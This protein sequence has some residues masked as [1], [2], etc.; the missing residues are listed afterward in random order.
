MDMLGGN[1]DFEVCLQRPQKET[2]FYQEIGLR[3]NDPAGGSP[4]P[5]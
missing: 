1:A 4:L 5:Y 3:W 2:I